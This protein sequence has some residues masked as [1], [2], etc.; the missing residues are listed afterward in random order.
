M[1]SF[2]EQLTFLHDTEVGEKGH[3]EAGNILHEF[4]YS[5]ALTK[6]PTKN[7]GSYPE[8][9]GGFVSLRAVKTVLEFFL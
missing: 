5:G 9:Y 8:V 1:G 7:G 4:K 6:R 3:E 2:D